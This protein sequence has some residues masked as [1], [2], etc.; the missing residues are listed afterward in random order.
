MTHLPSNGRR[1]ILLDQESTG[2]AQQ[3]EVGS[4]MRW[5]H[6]PENLDY[7]IVEIVEFIV[8]GGVRVHTQRF[9]KTKVI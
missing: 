4:R 1:G 7:I 6:F 5:V 3:G 8:G 9:D 2:S